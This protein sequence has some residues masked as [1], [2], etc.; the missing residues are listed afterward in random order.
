[1]TARSA[2]KPD[3][4]RQRRRIPPAPRPEASVPNRARSPVLR[5]PYVSIPAPGAKKDPP[6]FRKAGFIG[7]RRRPILPGRFQPSTFGADG[8]NFCVRDG[9]RWDPIAIATGNRIKCGA[10]V[11]CS[12]NR[13]LAQGILCPLARNVS[14]PAGPAALSASAA[15]LSLPVLFHSCGFSSLPLRSSRISTSPRAALS[16]G[17]AVYSR[18]LAHPDN[19]IGKKF[20]LNHS[21]LLSV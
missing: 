11:L 15:V 20:C 17:Q 3:P 6:S 21:S 18:P 12:A 1:M 14:S 10:E 7:I 2:T 5:H 4:P 16:A 8:L 13:L 9:N 19:R